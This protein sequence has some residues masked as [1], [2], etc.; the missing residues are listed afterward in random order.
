MWLT[1]WLPVRS[2]EWLTEYSKLYT[3]SNTTSN[4]TPEESYAQPSSRHHHQK[5]KPADRPNTKQW[6]GQ[7][8]P[9]RARLANPSCMLVGAALTDQPHKYMP[10]YDKNEESNY[11]KYENANNLYGCSMSEFLPHG[12]L[13][14]VNEFDLDRI[15]KTPDDKHTGYIIEVNLHFVLNFTINL[16][17]ILQLP[18]P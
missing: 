5:P 3:T 12:K 2:S 15:S 11:S 17:S 8:K 7:D 10:D 1:E 16:K 4:S 18:R 14:I 13:E 9:A 6:C